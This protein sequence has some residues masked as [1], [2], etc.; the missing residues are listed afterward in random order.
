MPRT[1]GRRQTLAGA[2]GLYGL[3]PLRRRDLPLLARWLHR[4]H[5]RAWWGPPV[6][7]LATIRRNLANPRVD[8]FLILFRG[9]PIGALQCY[10]PAGDWACALPFDPRRTRG[11][12]L[13]IG[14][15]G[16][17]GKGHGSTLLRQVSDALLARADV[18]RVIA[19]PDP[20]NGASIRAF[21]KAG[22][23]N[24]GEMVL[25]GERVRLL[26]RGQWCLRDRARFA[27]A[28]VLSELPPREAEHLRRCYGIGA[29]RGDL[30]EV[31]RQFSIT[32]ERIRQIEARALARL[33]RPNDEGPGVA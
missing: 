3:V 18:C 12:D 21:E 31:G 19:D 11:L 24:A 22:F 30:A 33:R 17:P 25:S 4:P 14:E 20:K 15:P 16:F 1:A 23:Y 13:F 32:R 8:D 6:R 5:A 29:E 2:R 7:E 28:R 9:R 10:D 26:V 27:V